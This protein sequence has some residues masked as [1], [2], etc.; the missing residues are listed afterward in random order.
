MGRLQRALWSQFRRHGLSE[1]LR[2][3]AAAGEEAAG[4]AAGDGGDPLELPPDQD[5]RLERHLCTAAEVREREQQLGRV[6]K[7]G[8]AVGIDRRLG[9]R[10]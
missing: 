3:D 10:R 8:R 5:A 7:C 2:F 9:D 1:K 6:W 4:G